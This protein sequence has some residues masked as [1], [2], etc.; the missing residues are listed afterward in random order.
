M[1]NKTDITADLSKVIEKIKSKEITT[2]QAQAITNAAD[3]I[4]KNELGQ[5][6][7]NREYGISKPIEYWEK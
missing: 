7:Y 6:K 1:K 5:I 3:K 4:I 2:S